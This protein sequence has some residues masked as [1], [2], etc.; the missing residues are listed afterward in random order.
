MKTK[1]PTS[2]CQDTSRKHSQ[3]LNAI[4]TKES[5][6]ATAPHTIIHNR[7]KMQYAKEEDTPHPFSKEVIKYI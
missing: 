5:K 6:L 3:D 1:K 7:V 2:T 4:N